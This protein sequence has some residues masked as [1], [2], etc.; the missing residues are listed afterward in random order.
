MEQEIKSKQEE[1]ANLK[2]DSRELRKWV[3]DSNLWSWVYTVFRIN[4]QKLSKPA[5]VDMLKGSIREDVPLSC[6]SYVQRYKQMHSDMFGE[7]SM[8]S[9]PTLKLFKRWTEILIGSCEFRKENPVVYEIG[10]IPCHFNEIE[11][12]LNEAFKTF[13]SS[14]GGPV[15]A[16]KLFLQI[17]KTYPFEEDTIDMAGA[18]LM[19]CIEAASLPVPELSVNEEEFYRLLM[20]YMNNGDA[21]PFTDMLLRCLYNRLDTVILVSKQAIENENNKKRIDEALHKL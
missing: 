18:V 9:T 16:A 13:A 1:L 19:Y 2:T 10:L 7:L 21:V 15:Q 5:V 3:E 8:Q 17:V 6:Y 14:G 4:G 11:E 20:P 12:Q